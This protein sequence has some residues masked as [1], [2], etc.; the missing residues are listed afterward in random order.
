MPLINITVPVLN[1]AG[2]LAASIGTLHRFLCEHCR[3]EF[4]IV[5]ADNGS[6][7]GTLSIARD[8]AGKCPSVRV[9]RLEEKGRG[10]ALKRAWSES[11]AEICSYMDVDLSTDLHAFP[12]LVESLIGGGFDL[13]IGSRLLKP[14]LTTRGIKRELIS[15]CYNLLVKAAFRTRFSDAQC[16]FKAITRPAAQTLLPLVEDNGWFLD[17][18]LLVLAEKLGYRIF[19]LPVQWNDDPDSRVKI[20]RTAWEDL[21]GIVRV[22]RNLWRGEYAGAGKEKNS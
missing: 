6:T 3:F 19:D 13:A 14:A 10:R 22:R 5:V 16:G 17:T 21:K 15:R 8:L 11:R 9:L 12:S 1:E 18:E 7:D 2:Q 20:A 4:E